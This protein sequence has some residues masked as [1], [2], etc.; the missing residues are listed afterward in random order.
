[1]KIIVGLGNPGEEY[2]NTRHNAGYLFIDALVQNR[3]LAPADQEIELKFDKKFNSLTSKV[4]HKGEDI[5]FMKPETFM[6]NSGKAV[7][8]ILNFYKVE[9]KDLIVILD[10]IDLPIGI[11][12]VRNECRTK[13]STRHH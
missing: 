12:R 6:N 4:R 11:I 13:G 3:D 10:D 2:K 1:M 7:Q 8:S 5:V 9:P